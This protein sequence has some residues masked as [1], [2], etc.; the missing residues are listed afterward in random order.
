MAG[1]WLTWPLQWLPHLLLSDRYAPQD[2]VAE[3]SPMPLILIHG[4]G[5]Q[6]VPAHHSEQLY[7]AAGAPERTVVVTQCSAYGWPGVA[8]QSSAFAGD[9]GTA[10]GAPDA[11]QQADLPVVGLHD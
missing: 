4:S 9:D 6:V 11:S 7:A 3:L 2:A 1:W 10:L 8:R 5:D